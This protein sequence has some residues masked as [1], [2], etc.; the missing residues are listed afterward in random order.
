[1]SDANRE[2]CDGCNNI[3]WPYN[4]ND[5]NNNNNNVAIW[6]TPEC[7][8]AIVLLCRVIVP[9]EQRS[10]D[11]NNILWP[12]THDNN[13]HVGIRG[14][15][16]A[17]ASVPQSAHEHADKAL[18]LA[19]KA[20]K[21]ADKAHQ[22]A[23]KAHQHADKALHLA[24]KA[25]QHVAGPAMVEGLEAA[26]AMIEALQAAAECASA[27]ASQVLVRRSIACTAQ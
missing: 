19:N 18:H 14:T 15:E 25:H 23:D 20:Y 8:V 24:E 2:K 9:T 17:A 5:N 22:H 27:G 6:G 4:D 16:F 21:H 13:N 7:T 10:A 3:L 11:C 12:P 26:A 1:L